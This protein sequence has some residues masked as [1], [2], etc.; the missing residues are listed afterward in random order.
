MKF[1]LRQMEVF[2]AVMLTGTVSGA[3]RML[4]VSQPAVSRLLNHTETSLG[5]KLFERTGGKLLPTSAA[6]SLFE[7]VQQVYDAALSV[8]RFVEHLASRPTTEIGVSC[9]PSLGL[10]L[11]PRV[12]ELFNQRSPKT[13]IRF[14]TTLT[15]DVP[16]ELLSKQI[17]LAVTVLPLSNPNLTVEKLGTGNMVCA[18]PDNHPLASRKAITFDD[19]GAH[20]TIFLSPS[21]AFGR[22]IHSTLEAHGIDITPTID[23][24]RAE[25]ACAL[26]KRAL[27]VAIVDEF[28]VAND[29]WA[30]LVVRPLTA[31]ITFNV[32][33][34]CAKFSVQSR[35][36]EQ[37]IGILRE[38]MRLH[39]AGEP[40]A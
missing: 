14:H 3:A 31:S 22:L 7:E 38:C 40:F 8:D 15:K 21:I 16:N 10:S 37:F 13:R 19:L 39:Q 18:M 4:Y 11:M 23:V 29:L 2:R 35:A 9:S 12:I 24:P 34:V 36:A 20:K 33:L 27:G 30:G 6:A 32:N 26:A 17:D 5:I 28:S 25:L 1:K